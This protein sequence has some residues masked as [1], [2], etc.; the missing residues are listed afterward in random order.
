M[1]QS[2]CILGR[3][4]SLGLAELESLY[5]HAEITPL[6]DSAI[7]NSAV[8][9]IEYDRLGGVMKAGQIIGSLPT[10]N[11]HDIVSYLKSATHSYLPSNSHGKIQLGLSTYGTPIKA[12]TIN[13]SLLDIKKTIKNSGRSIRIIPNK[14]SDLNTAQVLHNQLTGPNGVELLLCIK[15]R[16]TIIAKT[17]HIQNIEDYAARDQKRPKRDSR[18]GMLPPKLAQI[19]INLANPPQTSTVLDPFCGTGVLLQEAQ[20]MGYNVVGTDLE[21]R[22]VEYTKVNL[23]WLQGDFTINSTSNIYQGDATNTLWHDP[24][25]T[26]A[27]ELYLGTPLSQL[28]S[29]ELQESIIKDCTHIHSLFLKNLYNQISSSTRICLAVPAWR[30]IKGFQHL[31]YLDHLKDLGYTRSSFV[32]VSNEQL[33]YCRPEQFV[34]REL[35]LLKRI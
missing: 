3:Q 30:T 5:G 24:I 17:Y 22:M 12:A 8:E 9:T 19:I 21:P 11:W 16:R 4:P 18:V 23:E 29:Q 10:T 13:R 14:D 25:E 15:G 27:S 31:P 6:G 34:A 33:I 28:P 26:V 35:V 2:L 32:H 1:T 7:I 20:L